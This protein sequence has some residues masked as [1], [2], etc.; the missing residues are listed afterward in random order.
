[1][2]VKDETRVTDTRNEHELPA[3]ESNEELAAEKLKQAVA[4]PVQPPVPNLE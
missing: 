3:E 1:M 2:E 4:P